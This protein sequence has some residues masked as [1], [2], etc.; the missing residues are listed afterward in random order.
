MRKV[1]IAI[2]LLL[3]VAI[4][5]PAVSLAQAPPECE[6][7][8]T[9][10]KDDWLSKIADKYYDDISAYEA[11]VEAANALAD[12]PYINIEDADLIEPGWLLCIPSD[13]DP[14]TGPQAAPSGL[15]WD[16]LS[17]A[18]YKSE[19]TQNGT[20]PLTNG[21][22]SEAAAPGSATQTKVMLLP[23]F[24]AYGQ[25]NGQDAAVVVLVTDPGGSGTFYDLAVVVNQDGGPVNLSTINLGDR[26][27][28]NSIKIENNEILVDMVTQGPDDPMC[29]P[30]QQVVKGY[31]LKGDQ[32]METS[33]Q[34]VGRAAAESD[35]VGVVWNWQGFMDQSEQNDI[36][37]PN[38]DSYRLLLR[39][40]G[41]YS[42]KADCN[43]GSGSYTLEGNNLTISPLFATTLA[44]CGPGS[45]HNEYLS[46]L[47]QVVTYVREGDNL[48]LNL[49]AD[50]GNMEFSKLQAVSGRVVGPE[51]ATLPEGAQV[52]VKVEDVSL[53]DAPATQVGGQL[54][55]DARRF[56][57]DFEATFN[58]QAI[59]PNHTYGLGVTIRDSQGKLLFT[60]TTAYNVLTQGNPTYNVEVVVEPVD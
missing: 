45:L 53:A 42:F 24:I 13:D 56:P 46:L 44:E 57:I 37:V 41:Q 9:V 59:Q 22:Y 12:D 30:T 21:Q 23:D 11:I 2:S 40:D 50:A 36:V 20:A 7:A 16:A 18:T 60:N 29:C 5:V 4:A 19:W 25:L 58:P 35:I 27:K 3:L 38:P 34:V 31:A 49:V 1:P 26:V 39:P 32:L 51:G 48:Y 43:S 8:Y 14:S 54:I 47:G 33:S 28:I 15:S 55:F 6:F 10:Q 52:E 17:N